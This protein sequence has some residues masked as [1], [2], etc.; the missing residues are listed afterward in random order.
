MKKFMTMMFI[1]MCLLSIKATTIYATPSEDV[2]IIVNSEK[3]QYSKMFDVDLTVQFNKEELYND[4]V[5]LAYHLYD[6]NNKEIL[7]EGQ[8]F[9]ISVNDKGISYVKQTINLESG[10]SSLK[11]NYVK[12]VFDLVDEKNTYWFSLNPKVKV[13]SEVI[14]F[15]N[16][17]FKKFVGTLKLSFTNHPV[18]FSVNAAFFVLFIFFFFRIRRSELFSN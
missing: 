17:Y 13:S 7:W 16:D 5:Y 9:P 1:I 2:N 15:N 4:Q 6:I 12:V 10:L 11:D 3:D 18:I 14:I 8:R